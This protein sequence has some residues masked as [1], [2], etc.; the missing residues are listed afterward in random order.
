[1]AAGR[2]RRKAPSSPRCY[3]GAPG[4]GCVDNPVGL[5]R[6]LICSDAKGSPAFRQ[7]CRYRDTSSNPC[8]QHA[9]RPSVCGVEPGAINVSIRRDIDDSPALLE[10]KPWADLPGSR[11]IEALGGNASLGQN[12]HHAGEFMFPLFAEHRTD[13]SH[14]PEVQR[15]SQELLK[16]SHCRAGARDHLCRA[17]IGANVQNTS[18]RPGGGAAGELIPLEQ[19]NVCDAQTGKMISDRA[20]D[21][22]T[23]NDNDLCS[24]EPFRASWHR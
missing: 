9:R 3:F 21:Y 20:A 18:S 13:A 15:F 22:A 23:A 6:S 1:M 8:A 14:L 16:F 7:D 5:H 12:P 10:L 24:V 17:E 19:Q 4:A 11:R 2:R